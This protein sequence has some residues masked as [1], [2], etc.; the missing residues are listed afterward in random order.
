MPKSVYLK[1]RLWRAETLSVELHTDAHNGAGLLF[2]RALV[3][4][5]LPATAVLPLHQQPAAQQHE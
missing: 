2:G 4:G 3:L 1:T 5:R